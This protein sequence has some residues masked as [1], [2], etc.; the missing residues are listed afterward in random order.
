MIKVSRPPVLVLWA[1]V[2]AERLGFESDEALSIGRAFSNLGSKGKNRN[3][4]PVRSMLAPATHRCELQDGERSWIELMGHAIPVIGTRDGLRGIR[5]GGPVNP[6]SVEKYL[7]SSLGGHLGYVRGAMKLLASSLPENELAARAF[8]LFK[9]FR[10]ENGELD[11]DRICAPAPPFVSERFAADAAPAGLEPHLGTGVED[12]SRQRGASFRGPR[13]RDS[14]MVPANV[15]SLYKRSERADV[16]HAPGG[17]LRNRRVSIW[18]FVL[19][20]AAGA[21]IT[22]GVSPEINSRNYLV[23][24]QE[25][26]SS[27]RRNVPRLAEARPIAAE[28]STSAGSDAGL[29]LLPRVGRDGAVGD[30]EALSVARKRDSGAPPPDRESSTVS[31]RDVERHIAEARLGVPDGNKSPATHRPIT[32]PSSSDTRAQQTAPPDEAGSSPRGTQHDGSGLR[33]RAGLLALFED[34]ERQIAEQ[35][36]DQPEGDNALETFREVI[37]R[38]PD[39]A[40]VAQLRQR[41]RE[42]FLLLWSNAIAAEKQDERQQYFEIVESLTAPST[43]TPSTTAVPGS[44]ENVQE[45]AGERSGTSG[46]VQTGGTVAPARGDASPETGLVAMQRGN[47]LMRLGDVVAARRFYEFAASNGILEAASAVG[48]TFDP[49]YLQAARV[50]GLQAN[51]EMARQWYEK[52]MERGDS[53]ARLLLNRLNAASGDTGSR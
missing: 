38:W 34:A 7:R 23:A 12:G 5:N 32:A 47:D 17:R 48:R 42:E 13:R 27:P 53:A 30:P 31:L 49:A 9:E 29:A 1:A 40:R 22:L 20:L 37:A 44:A 28:I 45:A 2:V 52:A 4:N 18:L 50:R 14:R 16:T 11:P 39:D 36:L 51:P 35:R 6:R 3:V 15:P 8:D 24:L 19:I 10:P 43:A 41:L 21:G 26:L 25:L 46:P 33:E